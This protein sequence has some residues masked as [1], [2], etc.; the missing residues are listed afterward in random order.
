M[1][2]LQLIGYVI[3]VEI[4]SQNIISRENGACQQFVIVFSSLIL[5]LNTKQQSHIYVQ[6]LSIVL[7]ALEILVRV[8]DSCLA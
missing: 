7:I 2:Q 1:N 5:S 8:H 4:S 6:P 3:F